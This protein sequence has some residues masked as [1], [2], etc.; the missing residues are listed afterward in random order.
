M[1]SWAL[2]NMGVIEMLKAFEVKAAFEALV[3]VHGHRD[4]SSAMK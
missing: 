4:I 1:A 2:R 3:F